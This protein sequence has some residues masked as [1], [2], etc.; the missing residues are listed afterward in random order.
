M[1]IGTFFALSAPAYSQRICARLWTRLGTTE[2]PEFTA[3]KDEINSRLEF[4]GRV[5]KT[6][7]S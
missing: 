1:K 7:L 4:V 3:L 5:L 6:N 2:E